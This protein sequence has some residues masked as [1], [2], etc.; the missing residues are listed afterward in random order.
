MDIVAA[1]IGQ[2]GYEIL[3]QIEEHGRD[4]L[5]VHALDKGHKGGGPQGKGGDAVGV[6]LLNLAEEPLQIGRVQLTDK[7]EI[8]RHA[9]FPQLS[10]LVPGGVEDVQV[11]HKLRP[12]ED[13]EGKAELPLLDCQ[14][15]TPAIL[16][17]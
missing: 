3:I 8:H 14:H 12:V 17:R 4:T 9:E 15:L 1:H 16:G 5:G 11:E 6:A 2:V 13:E 7:V 10:G